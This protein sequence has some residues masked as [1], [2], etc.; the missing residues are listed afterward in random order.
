M[1]WYNNIIDHHGKFTFS[2]QKYCFK[3][4]LN[5]MFHVYILCILNTHCH[6]FHFYFFRVLFKCGSVCLI[7]GWCFT[8]FLLGRFSIEQVHA[9]ADT[10]AIQIAILSKMYPQISFPGDTTSEPPARYSNTKS[11]PSIPITPLI[12]MDN[13]TD[14]LRHAQSV[15]WAF[16]FSLYYHW[17]ND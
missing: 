2:I 15:L 4:L 8:L 17:L 1:K 13:P 5:F 7:C 12:T 9:N 10:V 6:I 14:S 16:H 3:V 11:S